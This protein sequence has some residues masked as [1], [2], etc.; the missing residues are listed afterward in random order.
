MTL[1]FLSKFKHSPGTFSFCLSVS[2]LWVKD[3]FIFTLSRAETGY[4]WC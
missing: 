4:E 1:I 3:D 2:T